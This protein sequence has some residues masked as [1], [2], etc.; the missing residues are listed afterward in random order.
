LLYPSIAAQGGGKRIQKIVK[1][2]VDNLNVR[3]FGE[4]T[5]LGNQADKTKRGTIMNKKLT[6]IGVVLVLLFASL[7]AGCGSEATVEPAEEP[8]EAVAEEPAEEEMAEEPAAEVEETAEEPAEEEMAEE[9]A[10]AA[11]L[12]VAMVFPGTISDQ[13]FNQAGYYGLLDI[14]EKLGAEIAYSEN[15]PVAEYEQVY[16]E[17]ANQGYDVIIGH[18]AEFG[19]VALAVAPEYPDIEFIVDS[20]PDVSAENVAGITGKTWQ[21]AY[22]LGALAASMS[23]TGKIGGIAGFDFP[24]IVSQMEAYRL[25]A[26]SVNPDIEVT[27]IYIGS[28]EDVA[29]AKEAAFAQID[30]GAD[31]IFHIADAAGIGVIQ[32]AEERGVY[33]IGWGLDQ[34]DVAPDTV[35]SSLISSGGELIFQDVQ[36]IVDG[37][38]TGEV[39]LYGLDTGVVDIAP[40]Y[41]LVPEDVAASIEEIKQGIIDGTIEVPYITEPAE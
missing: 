31:V 33:A 15:T 32:A 11:P 39:R 38:W 5:H 36:K 34:H 26:Q 18:G 37:T 12:K 25:G 29:T 8:A 1:R 30:A 2:P 21:A 23:E 40:Y 10:E 22:L 3:I 13:G 19:D 27:N 4:E 7:L 16:R 35:L 20:N 17:F 28:F 24:I 6:L 9:P 41:D 14:E